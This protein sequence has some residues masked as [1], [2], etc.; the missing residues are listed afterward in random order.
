M[1]I[2]NNAYKLFIIFYKIY[3]LPKLLKDFVEQN[4]LF[5]IQN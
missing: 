2:D 5:I 1:N 4:K 3:L